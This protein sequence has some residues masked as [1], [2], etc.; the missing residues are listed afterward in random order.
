MSRRLL[1]IAAVH[2]TRETIEVLPNGNKR[3]SCGCVFA[4]DRTVVTP[5]ADLA[6]AG[7]RL[8]Q[9]ER[10]YGDPFPVVYGNLNLEPPP[11]DR[12]QLLSLLWLVTMPFRP[13][14]LLLWGT[15]STTYLRSF[16]VGLVEQIAQP[17]PFLA[18]LREPWF[19]VETITDGLA[20]DSRNLLD[21]ARVGTKATR[22]LKLSVNPSLTFQTAA[23]GQH[24]RLVIAGAVKHAIV[25]GI[26]VD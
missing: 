14:D 24:M 17:F 2:F 6:A 15:N 11:P 9:V 26:S 10:I 12:G 5:C 23:P 22:A 1:Q 18:A 13:L 4:P 20:I 21:G 8:Q 3:V 16:T 19:P 7:N 25:Y